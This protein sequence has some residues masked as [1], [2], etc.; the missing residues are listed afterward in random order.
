[1]F[2]SETHSSSLRNDTIVGQAL[3]L[4]GF[5]ALFTAGGAAL[6]PLFGAYASIVGV[7]GGLVTLL[8]LVY[9]RSLAGSLRLGLFYLFSAFEGLFLGVVIQ[10]YLAAGLGDV[11]VLAAG[12]TA[13]LVLALSA[14][15]WT[16]QRDLSGLGSYLFVGL[17]GVLIASAISLLV[18][19]PAAHLAV[20]GVSAILFCG[21]ILYD[22]QRLKQADADADPIMLA[23][24]IYLDILNLFL[25]LLRILSYFSSDDD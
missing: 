17:V 19:A 9:A 24:D 3:G 21:Y 2:S 6:M 23:I 13:G 25:D 10:T 5:S 18:G 22:V 14:Y 1:M 8:G 7:A 16:T 4:L 11:V 15:A 20:A 12:T